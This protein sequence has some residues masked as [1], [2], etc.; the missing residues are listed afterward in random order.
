L[1]SGAIGTIA[2]LSTLKLQFDAPL[3]IEIV[4]VE[5]KI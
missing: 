1:F 5:I 3:A 2:L 4:P